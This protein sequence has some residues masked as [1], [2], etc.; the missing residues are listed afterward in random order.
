MTIYASDV[1]FNNNSEITYVNP[2]SYAKKIGVEAGDLVTNVY[3]NSRTSISNSNLLEVELKGPRSRR[4]IL[5]ARIHQQSG[6]LFCVF[7]K[8]SCLREVSFGVPCKHILRSVHEMYQQSGEANAAGW[9]L[10][11]SNLIVRRWKR[12]RERLVQLPSRHGTVHIPRTCQ[13]QVAEVKCIL[14]RIS[15]SVDCLN[16]VN[17]DSRKMDNV[18][19]SLNTTLNLLGIDDGLVASGSGTGEKAKRQ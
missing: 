18:I 13:N 6:V 10:S 8:C 9:T 11:L 15:T 17:R 3:T 14:R 4:V 2:N 19:R 5:Y 16:T 1:F 12:V 7:G